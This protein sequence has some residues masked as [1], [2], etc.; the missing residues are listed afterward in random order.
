MRLSK[1]FI[2]TLKENP[3]DAVIPS[4]QLMI[5]A[6]M[7]R[8]LASGVYSYLPL[9]WRVLEKIARIIR[10]EMNAIG[11]QEFFF[12]ALNPVEIWEESG[13]E[14][15]FGEEMFRLRDRKRHRMVLAPT[16]EEVVCDIARREIRSYK[17]LPQIWYQIQTKFRDEPRPRSGVVRARQF[18]MKDSYSL[19][20]DEEGLDRSYQ[21]HAEAYRNIFSRCGLKFFVVGASSGVMGGSVSQEF[22]VESPFGEDTVALCENCDYAANVDVA[23]SIPK[24][25]EKRQEELREVFTPGKKTIEQVSEF[26][27][28][29]PERLIKSMLYMVGDRPVMLLVRGDYELNESKLMGILGSQFRPALLDEIEKICGASAGFIGPVGLEGV[30]IIADNALKGQSGF[31]TG[32]NKDDYHLSGID[33]QRDVK[34]DRYADIRKVVAGEGCP[35]C[36]HPLKVI[37]AIEI[38]HIF[39]LGTKYSLSMKAMF[40]DKDGKEKPI[41][42][43]S[44]GIGLERIAAA[45]IEQNH[46][47]KGIIWDKA[48]APFQ[49]HIIP[50]N[51]NDSLIME[52]GEKIYNEL[53]DDGYEVIIDDRE[54]SP[55]F[56]FKDADLL[57][58]PLQIIIGERN[59]KQGKIELKPRATGESAVVKIEDYKNHLMY[60]FK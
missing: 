33:I 45:A 6:G 60:F 58:V 56:K 9:G 54:V 13:R 53:Q 12:P 7:I 49:I 18:I 52:T 29:E 51:I 44:Y 1:S 19:D 48:I 22:M 37:N 50:I 38:G 10:E 31:T 42:M 26:L 5:R 21:L 57:G 36:G 39:K 30:E 3:A 2:P 28:L 25:L 46:D 8:M 55:G 17:D 23:T 59:L 14:R 4:H 15:D 41:V 20:A 11:G 24:L 40:S 43:G 34:V 47:Q 32:A 27:N 16:H 35:Q